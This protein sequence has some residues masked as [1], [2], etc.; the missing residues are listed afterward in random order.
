MKLNLRLAPRLLQDIREDSQAPR[1]FDPAESRKTLGRQRHMRVELLRKATTQLKRRDTYSQI[2]AHR[3][4]ALLLSRRLKKQDSIRHNVLEN[5]TAVAPEQSTSSWYNADFLK[6]AALTT[7]L[8][9]KASPA[10]KH[11]SD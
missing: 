8:A 5:S 11:S 6:Q 7:T 9:E 2:S 10:F 4:E 3:K 1:P